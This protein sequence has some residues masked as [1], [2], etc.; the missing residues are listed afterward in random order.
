MSRLSI[1][2]GTMNVLAVTPVAPAHKPGDKNPE[3][4][5]QQNEEAANRFRK[6]LLE[7]ATPV[8]THQHIPTQLDPGPVILASQLPSEPHPSNVTE[9]LR[10]YETAAQIK[11]GTPPPEIDE[12]L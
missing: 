5:R 9:A 8:L 10:A 3:D 2:I 6:S 4:S 7:T 11:I 12:K 1:S